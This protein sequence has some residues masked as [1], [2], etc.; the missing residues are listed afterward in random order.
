MVLKGVKGEM[1]FSDYRWEKVWKWGNR[2]DSPTLP[3]RDITCT[4]H[5]SLTTSHFY[6]WLSPTYNYS[7]QY[8]QVHTYYIIIYIVYYSLYI[9]H[10]LLFIIH[11][12]LLILYYLFIIQGPLQTQI[13]FL[14]HVYH[15]KP[16]TLLSQHWYQIWAKLRFREHLNIFIYN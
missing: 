6:L 3:T 4:H 15:Q 9:I 2:R 10:Y 16:K 12:L 8:L 11:Y 1:Q 5:Y 13:P 7:P 14:I